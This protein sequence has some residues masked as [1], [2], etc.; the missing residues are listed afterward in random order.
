MLIDKKFRLPRIWSNIELKKFAHLFTGNVVNVSAWKDKDKEGK[1]YKDY[2][3][4]ANSYSITNYKSEARG[5]Q[6]IEGEIFLDLEKNLP[7]KLN[8]KF[9]VVFNHTTLEHI[10]NFRKAFKNLCLMTKDIV[11]IVVPFLQQMHA[12]YGDYWR[13]TPTAIK[14]MFEE[15]KMTVLYSSFNEHPGTSVYLFFIVSKKPAKWKNQIS[16]KFSY[17]VKN[18][19]FFDKGEILVGTRS[20]KNNIHYYLLKKFLKK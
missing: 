7:S 2:F 9:D 17:T 6:G 12:D 19:P 4:N 10:Y 15:Q 11:I 18:K 1:K 5:F 16:N 20:I 13:F 8:N 3:K 14:K